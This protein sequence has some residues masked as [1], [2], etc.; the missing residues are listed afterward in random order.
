MAMPPDRKESTGADC[1]F[2]YSLGSGSLSNPLTSSGP[3]HDN[4]PVQA[5]SPGVA[6][7]SPLRACPLSALAPSGGEAA[8]AG[9]RAALPRGSMPGAQIMLPPMALKHS[10]A[11]AVF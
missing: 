6:H 1:S 5:G 4:N 10:N 8:F 11:H 3:P 7:A 2:R 9:T